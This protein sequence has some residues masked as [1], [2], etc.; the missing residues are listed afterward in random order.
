MNNLVISRNEKVV[1][2]SIQVAENFDKRHD[3][4]LRDISS[5]KKDVPNFGVMFYEAMEPDAY[6]RNRKI[7]LMNRDGFTLLAMGFTGKKA[8]D[9]KIKY[10]EAFNEME[11]VIRQ[12]HDTS[13]LSPELQMVNGLFKAIANQELATKKAR[14]KG[15]EYERNP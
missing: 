7:I 2:S 5:L 4:I 1:T 6:G 14:N 3:H 9:F 12:Q 11:K 8:L 15:R 10:I 13:N